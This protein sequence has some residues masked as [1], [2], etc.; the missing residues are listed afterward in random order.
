[1]EFP[2]DRFVVGVQWHPEELTEF[3]EARRL[4][5]AFVEAANTHV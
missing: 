3:Q 1:V 4:F 2:G 5:A